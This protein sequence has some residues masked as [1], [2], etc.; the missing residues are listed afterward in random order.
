M[1]SVN[2]FM[3]DYSDEN[4]RDKS[5]RINVLK[6]RMEILLNSISNLALLID[7][8]NSE[9]VKKLDEVYREAEEINREYCIMVEDLDKFEIHES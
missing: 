9:A 7:K 4:I 5:D 3:N 2:S 1:R 6:K 8:N